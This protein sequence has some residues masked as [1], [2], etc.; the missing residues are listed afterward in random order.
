M[1]ST[2]PYQGDAANSA[3][4]EVQPEPKRAAKSGFMVS[5]LYD[6]ILFIGAPL[7]GLAAALAMIGGLPW[8][9][10]PATLFSGN[11]ASVSV[12]IAVWT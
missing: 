3:D 1:A 11:E 9:M 5:P 8:V 7:I 10:Q 4:P 6:G 2:I 12:F